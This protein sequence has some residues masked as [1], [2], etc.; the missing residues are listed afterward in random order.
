M[1]LNRLI[2]R[3]F[4]RYFIMVLVLVVC[5]YLI[6]DFFEKIDEFI[7]SGLAL[8]RILYFAL[9]QL[10]A[11]LVLIMPAGVMLAV[12][13]MFGFMNRYR[14]ILALRSSGVSVY[15]L[16][17]PVIMAGIVCSLLLFLVGEIVM[18]FAQTRS[19]AIWNQEV[20]KRAQA[21]MALKD[22]WLKKKQAILYVNFFDPAKKTV[23]GLTINELNDDNVIKY[24]LVAE[25]GDFTGQ[26]WTLRNGMEQRMNADGRYDYRYFEESAFRLDFLPEDLSSVLKSSDE[27]HFV[28]LIGLINEIE[29]DG[30]DARQYR[31]DLQGRFSLLFSCFVLCM[32]GAGLSVRCRLNPRLVITVIEGIG[33]IFAMWLLRSLFMSLGYGHVLPPFVAAWLVNVVF[34]IVAVLLLVN[35]E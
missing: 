32:I 4:F 1:I 31:V 13:L 26:S 15:T 25:S 16:V 11:V 6:I 24:R 3:E 33:V 9:L 14:E 30:Y 2:L 21:N 20:K 7:E 5:V 19:N 27:M 12:I 18:P 17:R 23:S 28:D 35:A 22:I 8:T 34:A 29:D 10:P